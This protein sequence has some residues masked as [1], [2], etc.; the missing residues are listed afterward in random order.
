MGVFIREKRGR[1]Y[2]DYRINGQRYWESIHLTVSPN[3][4]MNREARDLA[5]TIRAKKE[6]QIVSGEYGLID[7]VEGKRPLVSYAEELA[8]KQ[9]PK[10]PLPKSLRYL[11]EYAKSIQLGAVSERW[12]DGYRSF[13]LEQESLGQSTAAKYF[14]ALR[15][16]LRRAV[17][18]L[19]LP[20]NPADA[21]KGI[22]A[23][24]SVRVYL[25]AEELGKLAA[26]PIGGELGAEVKR[27]FLFGAN[28]GLRVSDLRS[29]EW[30]EIQKD[31]L[32][33]L[34][35]QGKTKRVVSVPLNSTAWK[36]IDD[37]SIHRRD[38]KVFPL[39]TS[40]K[41]NTNQYLITWA[42]RAGVDKPIGW[43]TARHTFA[44][45]TLE[46]GTEFSTVSRMLG[47]TK[48]QTTA[49]YAKTTDKTKRAA[50]EALPE[51]DITAGG[52]S[53]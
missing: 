50:V 10:N 18:D 40:S 8:G 36:I 39:L 42:A 48:I 15:M 33:V 4:K 5:E 2:L 11:R 35:R 47:H 25:T 28:T 53:T 6:F 7:P 26:T 24:E 9:D 43:H 14:D 44:T 30:G 37:K 45:L 1:L 20:R 12:V 31:P 17:R 13:L 46:A 23:P 22:T 29:L 52:K 38:E 34:K 27:A 16:L 3:E 19:I 51:L 41:A 32:Q 49:V 21:V